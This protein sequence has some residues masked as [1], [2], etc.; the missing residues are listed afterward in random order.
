MFHRNVGIFL[1]VHMASQP[2]RPAWTNFVLFKRT[3]SFVTDPELWVFDNRVLTRISGLTRQEATKRWENSTMCCSMNR[4]YYTQNIIR[5]ITIK[6]NEIGKVCR[7]CERDA[8]KIL[9]GKPEEI[10]WETRLCWTMS[11]GWWIFDSQCLGTWI[12]FCPQYDWRSQFT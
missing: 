7:T 4:S 6:E 12:A 5:T 9:V 11:I 3:W 8:Y 1:W 2:R 10:A